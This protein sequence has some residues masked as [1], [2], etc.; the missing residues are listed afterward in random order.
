MN[1][2]SVMDDEEAREYLGSR[3]DETVFVEAGAGTGKTT[4]IVGRIVALIA[5]G[6]TIIDKLVA[7]TFTEAAAAELRARV[8][9][10]LE[11]AVTDPE[12]SVEEQARCAGAIDALD[13]ATISTIHA[14]C[15]SLLRTYPLE[16]QL[17]PG[18]TTLDEIEQQLEFTESFRGWFDQMGDDATF[19]PV[20]GRALL[21]GL[22]PEQL[23]DAARGLSENYDLLSPETT[24]PAPDVP[25]AVETAHRLGKVLDELSDLVTPG[26]ETH[27]FAMAL[28]SAAFTKTQLRIASGEIEAL[29]ALG[30]AGLIRSPRGKVSAWDGNTDDAKAIKDGLIDVGKD[31]REDLR[32]HRQATLV[33]LLPSLRDL[34]LRT[35]ADRKRRGVATFQDLLAWT[36]DL[37]RDNAEVRRRAQERWT[38]M[39]VDEFQDTDPLQAEIVLY[40]CADPSKPL[41]EGWLNAELVAGKLCVVGDPKQSIYR[42]RRAD[43]AMYQ[44][45]QDA[46][47]RCGGRS[48]TLT[49][50]FRSTDRILAFVNAHFGR[51][52]SPDR[53]VQAQYVALEC[54]RGDG[55]EDVWVIGGVLPGMQADVWQAEATAVAR[56]IP[57]IAGQWTVRDRGEERLARLADICVLIPTR[58][59]VRR[60]ERAFEDANVSYRLESGALVLATQEVRELLACL[61][62]ID[63]PSDQVALV[64]ALRS[65]AYGCSDS[66]LLRWVWGGGRF[67]Y[68]RAR[69]RDST[70]T[71]S[72]AVTEE[73]LDSAA[74]SVVGDRFTGPQRTGD[75]RMDD[76]ERVAK[77]MD[78]LRSRH[79]RRNAM[80]VPALIQ[81]FLDDRLLTVAAFGQSRPREA[82]RRQRWILDRARAF[83]ET[84]QLGLRAFVDW[85]EGL[86]RQSY[87]DSV[88]AMGETDEDAVRVMTVHGAKGLEFPIVI[89]TGLGSAPRNQTAPVLAD[90]VDGRVEVKLGSDLAFATEGYDDAKVLETEMFKAEGVRLAY[91][92][93]T[94]ARDHLILSVFRKAAADGSDRGD[95]HAHGF[96]ASLASF[97]SCSNLDLQPAEPVPAT[98]R[99]PLQLP[100]I[101]E[102][103][104]DERAWEERRKAALD[105]EAAM[106]LRTATGL[107]GED[108]QEVDVP[109]EDVAVYRKGRGGTS[110]GRAVHGVLQSVDLV[111]PVNLDGLV[112]AQALAEGI[113][114]E[115][116]RVLALVRAALASEPVKRAVSSARFWREVPVGGPLRDFIVEGFIDLLYEGPDGLVVVDYKTDKVTD[117]E[118]EERLQRYAVQGAVYA[119]LLRSV[120][121]RPVERVDFVFAAI[122]R[123]RSFRPDELDARLDAVLPPGF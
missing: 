17:P 68:L 85:I 89:M 50:N 59:N 32:L 53:G 34:V 30:I 43:M 52:M 4:A 51:T 98:P 26:N 81:E 101:E 83:G 92:A 121:R 107:A 56:A 106:P 74:G 3:F 47:A 78:D 113:P 80:S 39:F 18:F 64:A 86:E 21:L 109:A 72:L 97:E 38:H 114:A 8:R 66:D 77:A 7:I 69:T 6:H 10:E 35:V 24:W 115:T 27:G 96:A 117:R 22:R 87:R 84:G 75:R 88:G 110:L 100:T 42:F 55:G 2:A 60:L 73:G 119:E 11:K 111:S 95:T 48:L 118:I 63:D 123:V 49:Q 37:L 33:G 105:R 57:A 44:A 103:V 36:R 122:G 14:F 91:V 94:R 112:A 16:A 20:C 45:V 12:R 58:T 29:I 54:A 108:K 102:H 40:L 79:E 99:V 104:A 46:V 1:P 82:W 90:R 13:N 28:A 93:A 15:G 61:R 116:G 62:A 70:E 5:L 41:S 71:E 23:S 65:Q 76:T 120:T 9:E 31:A 19:G 67:D 25:D